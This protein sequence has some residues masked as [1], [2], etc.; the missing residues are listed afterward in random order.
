[1]LLADKIVMTNFE[2]ENFQLKRNSTLSTVE[3][4]IENYDG[5]TN[6]L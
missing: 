4:R 3:D 6:M 5:V 1:M 2:I